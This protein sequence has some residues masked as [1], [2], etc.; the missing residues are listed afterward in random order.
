MATHIT[1]KYSSYS[2]SQ[3]PQTLHLFQHCQQQTK[4][5]FNFLLS[6]MILYHYTI[7]LN[8]CPFGES[9]DYCC[10]SKAVSRLAIG[11][12]TLS[13]SGMDAEFTLP[14]GYCS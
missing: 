5:T 10:Q 11:A 3:G 13:K 9:T 8:T 12:G 4:I 14:T 1:I 6:L 7:L 2:P